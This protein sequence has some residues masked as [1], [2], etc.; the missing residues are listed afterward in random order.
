VLRIAVPEGKTVAIGAEVGRIEP[1]E[2]G[3]RKSESPAAGGKD[4]KATRKES[5]DRPPAP[6]RNDAVPPSRESSDQP[7]SPAVRRMIEQEHLDVSQIPGTGRGGRVTKEDV[8][9]YLDRH[10]LSAPGEVNKRA[11]Q[12]W[13]EPTPTPAAKTLPQ[14]AA[15]APVKA[16]ASPPAPSSARG[17]QRQRMSPIRQR[18]AQRLVSSQHSTATLTT[19]NEADLSAILELRGRYKEMFKEKY[20]VGLG[21]MAFFV[22]ACVEALKTFPLLNS[23]IDGSDI[24]T[25][26]HYHIGVA[27]S[28]DK[29]L[30]VPVVHDADK[31]SFAQIEK[32]IADLAARARD[33]TIA[34]EDLQG[35]TFTITNGG[36]FGSLLSTPILYPGQS[37]ILG[38]HSIQQR[39]VVIKD[40]VVIRPMMYLALSYDHRLIDGRDAV[41]ALVRI[42]ECIEN[43]ERMLLEV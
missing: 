5:Q 16:P 6:D 10:K 40:Q 14:P 13:G 33:G 39:P 17:E 4:E 8:I 7:L 9:H 22:K 15:P 26:S 41:L 34:V 25:P 18:I 2:T 32:E 42:K 36:V 12:P 1:Q 30:I 27:V 20:D 19:F 11:E 31:L 28:T 23:H 35:G 29:G 24:V 38:M 3:A 21:F 37:G 43:P